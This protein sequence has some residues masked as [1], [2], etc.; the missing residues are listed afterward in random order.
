MTSLILSIVNKYLN[1]KGLDYAV[2][3]DDSGLCVE[4]LGGAPG[5]Y[6]ARYAVEHNNEANR[7]KLKKE[8][9]DKENRKAYGG[10]ENEL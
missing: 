5:V 6:S 9:L 10:R 2:L 8:L 7:A 1:S 4:A 3:A